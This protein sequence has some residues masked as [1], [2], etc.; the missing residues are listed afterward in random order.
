MELDID[1]KYCLICQE[2][3]SDKLQCP[4]NESYRR[5]N[6]GSGYATLIANITE[7]KKHGQE[8]ALTKLLHLENLEHVLFQNKG[9]WH[10]HCNLRYNKTKATRLSSQTETKRRRQDEEHDTCN[11]R[12]SLR[13]TSN[14]QNSMNKRR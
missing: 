8:V 10:K 7:F 12:K 11:N 3:T 2:D 5:K 13:L 4:A 9:K 14:F 1:F 6:V